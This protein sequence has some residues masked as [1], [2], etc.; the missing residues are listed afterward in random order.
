[1]NK[2]LLVAI[3]GSY[4][5]YY[6]IFRAIRI[7]TSRNK[8]EAKPYLELKFDGSQSDLIDSSSFK[9]ALYD[10]FIHV[11][12]SITDIIE[13]N[14][15]QYRGFDQRG[16]ATMLFCEDDF[17]SNSFRRK[18]YPDYKG[19]RVESKARLPYNLNKIRNYF[20]TVIFDQSDVWARTGYKNVFVEGAEGDDII[21]EAMTKFGPKYQDRLVI[22]ADK[23]LLQIPD[24]FQF[25]LDDRMVKRLGKNGL[26]SAQ[27]FLMIKILV[28]D[29]SDNIPKVFPKVGPV[30]A[31]KIINE[32]GKLEK[33]L[34]ES[35]EASDQFELNKKLID[36][37]KMPE[38]LS[39][40]IDERIACL[41]K[42]DTT[43]D[44]VEESVFGEPIIA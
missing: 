13:N 3:D 26:I 44:E 34:A 24:A 42:D 21:Y 15:P 8:K 35:K 40:T 7:W 20:T 10:A 17:T 12:Y 29:G 11:C 28:G 25:N 9:S 38:E 22:A 18:M 31:E 32:K 5:I 23:D 4:V 19:G 33:M 27:D 36:I 2:S 37:S 39:R 30:R 1:M 41:I 43:I 14:F 6:A 16:Y